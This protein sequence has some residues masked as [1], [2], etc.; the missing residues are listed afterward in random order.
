M[1]QLNVIPRSQLCV[2]LG[3]SKS[4]IKRWIKDRDIPKPLNASHRE[5]LF[6][7]NE[8]TGIRGAC[9]HNGWRQFNHNSRIGV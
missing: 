3:V 6:N 9:S 4:T 8:V 1:K 5:P 2:Q 7:L